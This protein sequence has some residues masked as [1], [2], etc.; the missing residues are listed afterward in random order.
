MPRYQYLAKNM[1]GKT[2]QDIEEANGEQVLVDKLQAQGYFV[3]SLQMIR[4]ESATSEVKKVQ[5]VK[6]DPFT[7]TNVTMDDILVF[8]RQLA[9]M[10]EA[11]IT[12]LRSL[13]VIISQ[14]ESRTLHKVLT[15]VRND[16]EQGRSLSSSLEKHPKQFSQFWVSLVEVG[17]A[18]GT[19]PQVLEK[20]AIFMEQQAAFKSIIISAIIYPC[21]LLFVCMGAIAF[22]AFFV[23][24]KFEAIY[25]SM[26]KELPA[27]T[28]LLLAVF[29]FIKQKII[30][31]TLACI[32]A[33]FAFKQY[34]KTAVGQMQ[35]ERFIF[36]LPT[37]GIIT[38][39]IVVE[40][41]ASQMSILI[42]SGV[43]ILYALTISEKLVENRTCGLIIADI[44]D[45]V[46]EGKMLAEPME[47][48]GFFPPMAVQMI[49]V[50][51][52]TGELSK[53]LKHVS[54]FF[55]REVEAFM[56]RF[57]TMIEP[58]MLLVMGA[59]IGTIVLAMFLPMFSL[60]G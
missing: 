13:D 23:G 15:Q 60:G 24:P 25:T 55:Q 32:A 53:M 14:L 59:V 16:V 17:E 39:K 9:T 26:G 50:G 46:R 21:I 8:A 38:K 57:G 29:K 22:F 19:M 20:L 2:V 54:G 48:S 37:F 56:K 5:K 18:S 10:L 12:L 11:G 33:S 3:I 4:V 49:K 51:E 7:H 30:L 44:R 31:I 52:E 1:E 40:R 28:K 47:L 42:D 34:I 27:F 58:L 41:F 35:F 6:K 36:N 45:S 43:P